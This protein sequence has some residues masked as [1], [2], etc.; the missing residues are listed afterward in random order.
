MSDWKL[1]QAR[2]VRDTFTIPLPSDDKYS[3]GVLGAITG[4]RRYPG[5]GVL[6]CGAAMESGLGLLR[7]FGPGYVEKFVLANNPEVVFGG[8][9]V[10]AWLIGSG[11]EPKSL[12]WRRRQIINSA[13]RSGEP[14]CLDAGAL[15][16]IDKKVGPTIITPHIRELAAIFAAHDISSSPSEISQDP[17][18]WA[19][20]AS[21]EFGVTVLLKGNQSVVASPGCQLEL[22]AATPWLATAG[23][24]DVL[25][26]IVGALMATN[27]KKIARDENALAQIG[28]TAI[29]IHSEAAARAA[30]LGPI[31][32]SDV[33][34]NISSVIA[35]LLS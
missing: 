23:T 11:I 22:P 10:D 35:N 2:N 8:K 26:G 25:A 21:L 18:K 5:A 3:R 9:R 17:K 31:S 14:L 13:C 7:Y 20:R 1:W 30:T 24:G 15:I 16:F 19:A 28:A 6:T 34:K 12:S 32:A 4:S 33:L 29:Y 27:S